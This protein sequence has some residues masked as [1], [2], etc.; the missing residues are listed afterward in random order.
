VR[1]LQV[2]YFCSMNKNTILIAASALAL[3]ALVLF[4]ISWYKHSK[5]ILEE[6]FDAT[7]NMAMAL[8]IQNVGEDPR[9]TCAVG[10]S[11]K[12]NNGAN[13]YAGIIEKEL[14]YARLDTALARALAFYNIHLDYEMRIVNEDEIASCCVSGYCCMLTPFVTNGS[15]SLQVLFPGKL[16]Y[17]REKMKFLL[18][19][20]VFIF[21]MANYLLIRQKRIAQSNIDFFNN[22]A[23]EFNTPLTNIGLATTLLSKTKEP[24]AN[25]RFL[26]II[27]NESAKLKQQVER[28]LQLM[29]MEN[30][31]L[32]LQIENLNLN[33]LLQEVVANMQLQIAEHKG[34]LQLHLP[35]ETIFVDA[36]RFHLG[37][38]FRNL[39]DNAIKY[40]TDAPQVDVYLKRDNGSVSILFEDAGVGI[41]L[42]E[43]KHVFKKFHRTQKG[44]VHTQKGFGLGLA[45]VKT[46]VE[47]HKGAIH[48][49]SEL[50]KGSRFDLQLPL[51]SR[52]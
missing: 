42:S 17:L 11:I 24:A 27:T 8:A 2:L 44:D 47:A 4:Q 49:F 23:H 48:L 22:M 38:A 31:S 1:R 39:I 33:E 28:F 13:A 5:G 19:A 7:V 37:N 12:D 29:K 9:T 30:G 40:S 26:N 32:Q 25:S 46:I 52:S 36:D 18:I 10:P 3:I 43:Q 51:N 6:Q 45:Y 35:V 20:C 16:P 15:Q 50:N 34:R 14:D 41:P 21:V